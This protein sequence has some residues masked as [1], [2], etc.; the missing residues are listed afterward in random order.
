MSL[1][2]PAAMLAVVILATGCQQEPNQTQ[3]MAS[4]S[5]HQAAGDNHAAIIELKNVLQRTP[6]NAAARLQLGDVYLESGDVLSAE[7]EFRRARDTGALPAAVLPRL[8]AALLLQQ[9][10]EQVLA[11]LPDGGALPAAAVADVRALR[12]YALL[13]LKRTNEAEQLFAAAL[14]TQAGH[15]PALLGQARLALLSGANEAAMSAVNAAL[16]AHADSTEALRMQGDLYRRQEDHAK[17]LASYRQAIKLRPA[18]LQARLDVAALLAADNQLGAAR[19]ELAAASRIA[20]GNAAVIYTEALLALQEKKYPAALER[21]QL[22]LRAAPDHPPSNLLAAGIYLAQN[23]LPLA[24]QHVRRFLANQPQHAFGMRLAAMIALRSGKPEASIAML[25]PLLEQHPADAQLQALAGE[26]YMRM[27]AYSKA[28]ACFDKATALA[29]PSA[30][31]RTSQAIS[32]LGIGDNQGAVAALEAVLQAPENLAANDNDGRQRAG[33]LLVAAHMRMGAYDKAL[34]AVQALE[35]Q[36]NNPALQNLKG[37]VLLARQDPS[38]ARR[39]FEAALALQ[40]GYAPALRNLTQLDMLAGH[41][42]HAQRRYQAALARDSG[43]IEL[44]AGL[45][46]LSAQQGD[47]AAARNWLEQARRSAPDAL[48]PALQLA[49]Y[50][51]ETNEVPKGLALAQKLQA[52]NPGSADALALLARARAAAGDTEGALESYTDLAGRQPD[53]PAVHMQLAGAYMA[54]NR[55]ADALA[56]CRKVLALQPDHSAALATAIRLM[57]ELRTWD[58]AVALARATQSRPD[59]AGLGY[60]LEG[61]IEMARAHP[62]IALPLYQRSF[63]LAPSGPL[64][65]SIHRALAATGKDSAAASHIG[66]WLNSHPRDLPTR[67]YFASTLLAAGQFRAAIPQYEQVLGVQPNHVV[68]LNDLAWSCLQID[69]KRALGF[70]EKAYAQAPANAAVADTLGWILTQQ[71]Q[72]GRAVP[73]LKKAADSA[74]QSGDIRLHYADALLRAGERR[75]ARRQLERLQADAGYKRQDA[76]RTLMGTL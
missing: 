61:D 33:A 18:S 19:T 17:A 73:I 6:A 63:N 51:L 5:R 4:A 53:N 57:T 29:P 31:L 56:A 25:E 27:Q 58:Q 55:T 12:G 65:I 21:L 41:P 49:S 23:N 7:K 46:H 26:S 15:V 24:E 71:G 35:Q 45:A 20:P 50:Y 8:G 42:E 52:A 54:L 16:A 13:G 11:E 59:S 9:R 44:M 10:Y 28:S 1:S 30:M 76:V 37:G 39:A 22:I 40:P 64:A 2:L 75:E 14:A 74:P 62:A 32:Q 69:D 47:M 43:N 66:R 67:M 48:P 70:A 36:H 68:A 34:A 38:G 3:L 72:P 60:R